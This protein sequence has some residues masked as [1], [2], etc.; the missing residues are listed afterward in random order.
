MATYALSTTSSY[1]TG[2][3]QISVEDLNKTGYQ[4]LGSG[5]NY[6]QPTPL[7]SQN[8]T[9]YINAQG[10]DDT[11]YL[12]GFG[13]SV[14]YGGSGNDFLSGAGG[15]DKFYGGSG[16][17]QLF[18]HNGDDHLFGEA[19]DDW[20]YGGAGN[21]VLNGGSGNDKLVGEGG[22]DQLYGGAGADTFYFFLNSWYS[23]DQSVDYIQDFKVGEDKINIMDGKDG[24][25]LVQIE[26]K[27]DLQYVHVENG[28]YPDQLIVVQTLDGAM[29][30]GSDFI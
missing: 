4:N 6:L 17:D 18:G 22:S 28:A 15:K 23:V 19:G 14:V 30:T 3:F 5:N 25:P 16:N 26:I 13:N 7:V 9:H 2:T 27:G 10:G 24:P 21:D 29:L 11:I 8:Y 12:S 20:I 1:T